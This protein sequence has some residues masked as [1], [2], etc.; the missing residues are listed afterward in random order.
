VGGRVL[1]GGAAT[2]EIARVSFRRSLRTR[3]LVGAALVAA[4]PVV[5][6]AIFQAVGQHETRGVYQLAELCAAVLVGLAVA[7]P[8]GEELEDRTIAYLWARPLPHWSL[9]TGKLLA[10]VPLVSVMA[11]ALLGLALAVGKVPNGT[12]ER[13]AGALAAGV[14]VRACIGAAMGTLLPRQ[15]LALTVG[16]LFF[17]DLP[18]GFIPARLQ[19]VSIVFHE[20]ALAGLSRGE[21]A[22]TAVIGLAAIGLVWLA[23]ALWRVRRIE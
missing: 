20:N 21:D 23:V 7:G 4:L 12:I 5:M 9:V 14:A 15:A 11:A 22:A 6:A 17:V 10:L 8:L 2:V 1:G 13:A 16:Y 18:L 19:V 3:A